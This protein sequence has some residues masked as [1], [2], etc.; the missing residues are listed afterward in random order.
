[1]TSLTESTNTIFASN[2]TAP[3][4]AAPTTCAAQAAAAHVRHGSSYGVGPQQPQPQQPPGA[5]EDWGDIHVPQVVDA[6]PILPLAAFYMGDLRDGLPMLNMQAAFLISAKGFNEKQVGILFFCFGISQFLCMAPAGYFL[7]YSN[8]KIDWVLCAGAAASALTVLTAVTAEDDGNNMALMI[9]WKVLQGGVTAILPPGFNGITLGIVGSTGF[10]HQVSRNRMMNHIGTALIVAFGSLLAYFLYPNIGA[11][12]LVSPLASIGM[13]YNLRRIK[14]KHVDRDA[15]RGLIIESPTMNEYEQYDDEEEAAAIEAAALSWQM[16]EDDPNCDPAKQESQKAEIINQL[17]Y[18]PNNVDPSC[19]YSGLASPCGGVP[20]FENGMVPMA[21]PSPTMSATSSSYMP[22]N[23]QNGSNL[24][25]SQH[26]NVVL[27]TTPIQEHEAD[28]FQFVSAPTTAPTNTTEIRQRSN[29]TPQQALPFRPPMAPGPATTSTNTV[30]SVVRRHVRHPSGTTHES[31]PSFNM[32]YG[33][34]RQNSTTASQSMLPVDPN[35]GLQPNSNCSDD[36]RP[37]KARTPLAVLMDPTLMIFTAVIFFFHLANSSVLPLVMQS[38]ALEDPQAGIL[39]SGLCI[40]IAQAFMSYFAKICGD[41]SP[42][43]GRKNLVLVGLASLTLRCFLLAGLVSAEIAVEDEEGS[44]MLKVLILSTQFL[45]AVGAGILGCLH[46]LVTNDISGG[47]GRFSLMLG[48]TTG[49]M[50]LGGTVSGYIGQA[51]AQDYGYPFAFTALGIMSLVP[52]CLY[53]LFMPETLPDY[54][55]PSQQ[56]FKK[57]RKRLAALF[58]RLSE[59]RRRLVAKANPFRK[60]QN[61]L[62]HDTKAQP[63]NEN[64]GLVSAQ[65][66]PVET[67]PKALSSDV[68]LV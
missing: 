55:R 18:T 42:I 32:G 57:R 26:R 53:S 64:D 4:V 25:S 65:M 38:L 5:A 9:L 19:P 7:D 28:G 47:T 35:T 15:A 52:L 67:E 56:T 29:P 41:Y 8:R 27:L 30:E 21:Q 49:A 22:P 60:S 11:L 17:S 2:T 14:P 48:V 43:W 33:G 62:V 6:R 24:D 61:D 63:L 23:L 1:M 50:C 46:I 12:F 51:I 39:L 58:K 45:D 13:A 37:R 68:E 40:L 59:S 16:M 66:L 54:A 36:D 20:V 31:L 3:S 44:N 10:T 34:N